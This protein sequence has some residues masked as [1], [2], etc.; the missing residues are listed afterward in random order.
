MAQECVEHARTPTPAARGRGGRHAA[1]APAAGLAVGG[2]ESDRDELLTFE[3][4]NRE[5]IAGLTRGHLLDSFVR[6]EDGLSQSAGALE[7]HAAHEEIGH[8]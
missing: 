6:P 7:R 2:D 8:R 4:A 1:Y 5:R 3:G